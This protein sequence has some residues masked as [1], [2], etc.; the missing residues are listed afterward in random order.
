MNR[1]Q[2]IQLVLT[3]SKNCT[4]HRANKTRNRDLN[5]ISILCGSVRANRDLRCYDIF[6]YYGYS[7]LIHESNFYGL[8]ETLREMV[9]EK[10]WNDDQL[11]FSFSIT[12][13][14]TNL[15]GAKE[16]KDKG[17]ETVI[18]IKFG[19][20]NYDESIWTNV[21]GVVQSLLC[22]INEMMMPTH[23][24]NAKNSFLPLLMVLYVLVIYRSNQLN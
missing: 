14:I 20:A 12:K 23:S 8:I 10:T 3:I 5:H 11:K 18:K 9:R 22:M 16:R 17:W 21:C 1:D 4:E 13:D 6:V 2:G 15:E 7:Y 24:S 19:L